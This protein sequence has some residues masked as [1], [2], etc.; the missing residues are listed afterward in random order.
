VDIGWAWTYPW[1]VAHFDASSAECLVLTFKEGL[2]SAVA[3]DLQI[4][5]TRF[6]IDVDDAT[7]AITAR[8][9]AGSLKVLGAVH[10]GVLR[11]STLS[12]ADKRKI[13]QN[14]ADDVLAVRSYPEIRFTS[15]EVVPEGDGFRVRGE[16]ALHGRA[17]PIAFTAQKKGDRLVAEVPLHQPDFG[18][19]PYSAMLGALK[20]KPDVIVRCSVPAT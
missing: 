4:R 12:D 17:R 11:E 1:F 2:L 5:V 3:H 6:A 8:F 7:R 16:L 10:D 14:I 19:K 13:E 15:S 9:E 20:I 18:I